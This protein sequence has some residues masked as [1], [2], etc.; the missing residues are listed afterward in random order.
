MALRYTFKPL[1]GG[2]PREL[3][4]E[5][6]RKPS[7]FGKTWT[8][9]IT[10][11]EREMKHLGYRPGSCVIQTAHTAYDVR[12]DGMLRSGSRK[13]EHPGVVVRFDV[14][15]AKNRRYVPMRFECDRF[16]SYEAN[17]RAIA[18]ALEALRKVDRY[19]VSSG[20]NSGAHYEGYKA[21]PAGS[22]GMTEEEAVMF[23]HRH[24]PAYGVLDIKN[25][26]EIRE[27]AYRAAAFKL[28]PDQGGSHDEFVKLQQ[29]KEILSAEKK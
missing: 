3:T 27:R 2:F 9:I 26:P 10:I 16:T 22:G 21:L 17:V 5:S 6:R 7:P 28:H 11:L 24:A 1:D 25:F 18:D 20:G 19:G 12:N 8:E 4:P 14:Y 29:A 13:P 23:I 15:D